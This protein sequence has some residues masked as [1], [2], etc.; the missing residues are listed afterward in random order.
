MYKKLL[1]AFFLS[2]LLSFS[3]SACAEEYVRYITYPTENFYTVLKLNTSNGVVTQVHIGVGKDAISGEYFVNA[4]PLANT[5]TNGRFALQKTGNM[6][7][8]VLLDTQDGRVWQLQWSFKPE[9]RGIVRI[10]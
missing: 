9:N 7:N 6:Y 2:L 10:Y 3:M 8:F 1:I 4:E 5:N